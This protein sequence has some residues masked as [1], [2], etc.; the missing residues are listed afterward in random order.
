MRHLPRFTGSL[1][2]QRTMHRKAFVLS[3]PLLLCLVALPTADAQPANPCDG[4]LNPYN[5]GGNPDLVTYCTDKRPYIPVA[6]PGGCIKPYPDAS[7]LLC[8]PSAPAALAATVAE[9]RPL[10]DYAMR[11]NIPQAALGQRGRE[12]SYLNLHNLDDTEQAVVIE[13]AVQGRSGVILESA[14]LLPKTTRGLRL[15]TRPLLAGRVDVS[16]TVY[17]MG[18][19]SMGMKWLRVGDWVETASEFGGIVPRVR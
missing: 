19:G 11:A 9:L 12:L 5:E 17:F 2:G 4:R 8:E 10:T 13:F 6:P 3:A 15:D 18:S 7:T 16:V 14:T 1:Q